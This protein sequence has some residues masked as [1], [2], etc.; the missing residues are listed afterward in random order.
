MEAYYER[1]KASRPPTTLDS[2]SPST[3]SN[4]Q[5]L[6][7]A[8]T[9]SRPIRLNPDSGSTGKG[10]LIGMLSAFGSAAFVAFIFAVIYFFR[11]TTRGRIILDRLGGPG[12]FDDEQALLR[13][14]AEALEEMDDLS[15][16]E[17]LRAKGSFRCAHWQ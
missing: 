5:S 6:D 16:A 7:G 15:R 2:S 13:E 1:I 4:A 3:G 9:M 12:E 8:S 11:H 14:E 17:Y 10:I